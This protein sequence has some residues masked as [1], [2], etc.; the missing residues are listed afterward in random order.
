MDRYRIYLPKIA[1]DLR[2]IQVLRRDTAVLRDER[3]RTHTLI[4]NVVF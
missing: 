2:Y 4:L 1:G 3:I